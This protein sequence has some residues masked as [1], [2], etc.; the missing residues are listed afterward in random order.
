VTEHKRIKEFPPWEQPKSRFPGVLPTK[1]ERVPAF[2]LAVQDNKEDHYLSDVY[3]V[4]NTDET[5]DFVSSG[6]GGFQT[7][8]EDVVSVQGRDCIYE[9]VI[10]GEA[11]LVESYH[12]V[13]DSDY[14]LELSIEALS[15]DLGTLKFNEVEK[16]GFYSK[17]LM[18]KES[19]IR[20]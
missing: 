1:E 6:F 14:L 17:V 3:F 11:V 10:P 12:L 18:W 19:D 4:N 13:Y 5:L 8:D 7:C 15:R 20:S 2:Y 9:K 16:G